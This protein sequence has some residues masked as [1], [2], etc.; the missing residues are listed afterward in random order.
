[1]GRELVYGGTA[2]GGVRY[3]QG[4]RSVVQAFM[5]T[6][7]LRDRPW[8]GGKSIGSSHVRVALSEHHDGRS[9]ATD[10]LLHGAGSFREA[11]GIRQFQFGGRFRELAD[12]DTSPVVVFEPAIV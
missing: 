3:F 6:A 4:D 5:G 2:K 1:M 8:R 9:C 12:G 10:A 7:F 11:A